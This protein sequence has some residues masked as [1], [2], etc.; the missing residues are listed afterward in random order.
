[1]RIHV[2][3]PGEVLSSIAR[4]YGW[5][6]HQPI[7]DHPRN[8]EFKRRR[9]DPNL[10]FPGDE[11]FIPDLPEEPKRA[12]CATGS[13]H[14]FQV[15]LRKKRLRIVLRDP[16]GSLLRNEP[17]RLELP[18]AVIEEHTN[19]EGL[20]DVP[21][22]DGATT[23]V[24]TVRD[25]RYRL[26]IGDLNPIDDTPDEGVSG[27][28]GRLANLG[29]DVGPIDGAMGPRTRAAIRAF[30]RDFRLKRTGKLDR[31][32]LDKLKERHRS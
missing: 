31:P 26:A 17:F 18:G 23:G 4:R 2:V 6:S 13:R 29:Y 19:G 12:A 9:P 30:Q 32:T 14:N 3:Q 8:A 25:H 16:H 20:L 7:Y 24:L 11:I 21:L 28:Q 22:P 27:A 10:I 5:K 15:K 1:M